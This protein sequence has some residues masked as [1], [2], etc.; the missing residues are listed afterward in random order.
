MVSNMSRRAAW[1]IYLGALLVLIANDGWLKGAG[2][3][4]GWLTGKLSDVAGLV[5]APVTLTLFLGRERPLLRH[6]AFA[7]TAGVF[8]LVN[9]SPWCSA[10]FIE[11]LSMI[12]VSWTL[13]PDITDLV[14]LLILPL[15]WVTS[16]VL[17]RHRYRFG[18]RLA[19]IPAALA[20]LASG[21]EEHFGS[22]FLYN[23]GEKA[24]FVEVSRVPWLSCEL[25]ESVGT[26]RIV[27]SDFVSAGLFRL[28]PGEAHPLDRITVNVGTGSDCSCNVFRVSV[29]GNGVVV[30]PE[31]GGWRLEERPS[32][33]VVN[34]AR[35]RLIV[36]EGQA[37]PSPGKKLARLNVADE[38][39]PDPQ[40]CFDEPPA[41]TFNLRAPT[42]AGPI[43]A[44]E[45]VAGNCFQV[46]LDAPTGDGQGQGGQPGVGTGGG[47]AGFAGL[48]GEQ[49]LAG[50]AAEEPS[51][52]GAERA[53]ICAPFELFPFG[54]GDVV[55][56]T[57][58]IVQQAGGET[59]E[60][61]VSVA[62]DTR[63]FRMLIGTPSTRPEWSGFVWGVADASCGLLRDDRGKA[64]LPSR[65]MLS[66]SVAGS[67]GA[68]L[69]SGEIFQTG[70]TR[71][72]LGRAR[73]EM[74]LQCLSSIPTRVEVVE[75]RSL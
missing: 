72:Y 71:Y 19:R 48:G 21:Q 8:A 56:M 68:E 22:A 75:S 6:L 32:E 5:V 23:Q 4:P 38:V 46:S 20:C 57:H 55:R 29:A 58:T 35:E 26:E 27:R 15:S 65:V 18:D 12:G 60:F 66:R 11:L 51:G 73:H 3:L 62:T 10:R 50:M 61:E 52:S 16:Q 69:V 49:G 30:R 14:A 64:W 41:M 40:G 2:S 59:H 63:L 42:V 17:L 25:L 70:R 1:V 31:P 13:W 53:Y 39:E 74:S 9:L 33:R 28:D 67:E 54:S 36:V 34:K 45:P 43:V 7:L 37:A 24:A 47:A 44:V